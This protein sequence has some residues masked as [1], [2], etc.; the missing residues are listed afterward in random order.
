MPVPRIDSS[1]VTDVGLTMSKAV[2]VARRVTLEQP[3][4]KLPRN[5]GYGPMLV[6]ARFVTW[7][8]G[9]G[10]FARRFSR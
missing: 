9:H 10:R 7:T 8:A 3:M 1:D 4:P 2:G 6:D 5:P